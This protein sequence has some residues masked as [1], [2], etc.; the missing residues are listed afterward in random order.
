MIKAIKEAYDVASIRVVVFTGGEPTLFLDQVVEGVKL[1]SE[2][3]FST[4]LVTNGWWATTYE[5]AYEILSRL[6]SAGLKELNISYDRFHD[7][8]LAKFGGFT[9]VVNAVRAA[10]ELGIVALIGVLKLADERQPTRELIKKRLEE[11]GLEEVMVIED[12]P[13]RI[14]RASQL[15]GELIPRNDEL[16]N[17]GCNEAG[18]RLTILPNGDAMYC[19]GH[20]IARSEARWFFKVGNISQD[21]LVDIVKRIR[22]NALVL[23]LRYA[24][25]LAILREHGIELDEDFKTPCE[26]CYHVA[27]RGHG[28]DRSKLIKLAR[29]D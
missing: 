20:P 10:R 5:K 23:A 28:L 8:W 19:C 6:K 13:A 14:G 1:A 2:L 26:V 15:P 18:A 3:G 7:P 12:F 16:L 25:P 11:F 4:R 22:R 27:T 17:M 24:G 21:S 9:N 29:L